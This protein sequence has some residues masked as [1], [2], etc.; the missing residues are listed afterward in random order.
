MKE[1]GYGENLFSPKS[2]LSE[3]DAVEN[4]MEASFRDD[5]YGRAL[6]ELYAVKVHIDQ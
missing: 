1:L 3:F 5:F 4:G 6:R 2:A